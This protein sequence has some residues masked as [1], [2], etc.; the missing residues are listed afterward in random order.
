MFFL[1]VVV[2]IL[3]FVNLQNSTLKKS[4]LMVYKLYFNKKMERI[5]KSK[6]KKRERT[7]KQCEN[8]ISDPKKTL[9][10]LIKPKTFTF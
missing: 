8:E 5:L 1:L 9:S 2:V 10:K 6:K 7:K 3:L 4:E